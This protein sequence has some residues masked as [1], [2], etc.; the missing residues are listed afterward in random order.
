MGFFCWTAIYENSCKGLSW[1]YK[2]LLELFLRC[3]SGM[4]TFNHLYVYFCGIGSSLIFFCKAAWNIS[5]RKHHVS[6][7]FLVKVISLPF[8][9]QG[10]NT[11]FLVKNNTFPDSSRNT[12]PW[13]GP[14]WKDHLFRTFE[15]NV[16]FRVLFENDHLS[17]SR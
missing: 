2:E 17:F 12:M 10:K 1:R 15:G 14:F 4:T 3:R 7:Y 6:M 16:I 13:R 5:N 11:M 8:S 9:I